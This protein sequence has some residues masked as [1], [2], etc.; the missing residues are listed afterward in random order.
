L[1]DVSAP[2]AEAAV[3]GGGFG[4]S[5]EDLVRFGWIWGWTCRWVI[6]NQD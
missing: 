4:W 6:V 5:M 2:A 1:G 3:D